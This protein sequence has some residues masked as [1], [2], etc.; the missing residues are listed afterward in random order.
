MLRDVPLFPLKTVLFPEGIL[1]L[2]VFEQRYLAM[3]KVCLR[4]GLPFGVC[5]ITEG[6]EVG[7]PA[8]CATIGTL[9]RVLSWDMPEL[10]IL[11]LR[12]E[13]GS[14]FRVERSAIQGDG[15]QRAD[16][17]LLE[18]RAGE[19]V[20]VEHAPLVNLLAHLIERVGAERFG[21]ERR[22]EDA[23][24]VSWRLAEI[25]PLPL[26]VRQ[27]LLEVSEPRARLEALHRFVRRQGLE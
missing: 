9:A 11:H 23:A 26:S 1:P 5:A 2:R 18:D 15:L 10:G 7:D 3:S 21:S 20:C 12:T 8:Q 13:G 24:W 6:E 22:F 16:V 4:D 14:R 17:A 25:L 19:A 27:A